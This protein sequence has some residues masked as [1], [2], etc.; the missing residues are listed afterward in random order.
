MFF[1]CSINN[2]Q[3]DDIGARALANSIFGSNCVLDFSLFIDRLKHQFEDINKFIKNYFS[4]KILDKSL[5]LKAPSI[6]K[7]SYILNN[8]L[9]S[10]LSLSNKA[11]SNYNHLKQ[12]YSSSG[13]A[14]SFEK[15]ASSLLSPYLFISN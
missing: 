2:S 7:P 8:Q 5:K 15:L 10:L 14:L 1:D 3:V 6:D 9:I 13:S 12:I 11:F 4:S